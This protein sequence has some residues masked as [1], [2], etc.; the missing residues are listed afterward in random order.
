MTQQNNNE[1]YVVNLRA[2]AKRFT[3]RRCKAL[4]RRGE[5]GRGEGGMGHL[6][7]KSRPGK[8][9]KISV[10]MMLPIRINKSMWTIYDNCHRNV[11]VPFKSW[12]SIQKWYLSVWTVDNSN[13]RF[14]FAHSCEGH[15]IVTLLMVWKDYIQF[16]QWILY[17]I[18][19][20][21]VGKGI[22]LIF[23]MC[24]VIAWNRNF[25]SLSL[26]IYRAIWPLI[27]WDNWYSVECSSL[28]SGLGRAYKYSFDMDVHL[29]SNVKYPKK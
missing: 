10:Q 28:F 19:E 12:I 15:Y 6:S 25:M 29:R 8:S 17:K 16:L 13:P 23:E 14:G 5:G 26:T 4:T 7:S 2:E 24:A 3:H 21:Q 1:I 27:T 20:L 18:I 22:L 9:Y 11:H